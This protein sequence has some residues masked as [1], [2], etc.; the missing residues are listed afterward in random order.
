M[1]SDKPR[2]F[3]VQA[4][5]DPVIERLCEVADV[6]V[7]PRLDRQISL[8]ETVDG[9][10]RA[11]YLLALHGNYVPA[12]VMHA[13]PRL[14][15]LAVLGD[16]TVKVDFD[17]ARQYR[18]PVVTSR[19]DDLKNLPGGGY[20]QATAD[21][22]VAML[23]SLAYRLFDADRYTRKSATF[24]EQTMALMGIGAPGNTVGL[25]GLGK[26]A[27]HMVPRLRPFEMRILYCKRTRLDPAE[28]QQLGIEWV[29]MDE[30]LRQSD[31]V[32]VEVDYNETTHELLGEREFLLMKP[33][34]YLLNTAR[35]R[36][37]DE[38][39]L[40]RALQN[41]T[42]AGAG[43]DVFYHEPPLMWDPMVP[44]ELRK[45][46]NVI[47]APH[48]GGATYGSRTAQIMP[49]AEGIVS[50]IRGER[51]KGLLNPEVYGE[52]VLYP[53]FYGRGPIVPVV[54]G[55]PA[56]FPVI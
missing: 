14:K 42:I 45:M 12:E 40:I 2:V 27:R 22:T 4:I 18:I 28:E 17:T 38:K 8:Q 44:E 20:N 15:G 1:P 50:L 29:E 21:L 34:A 55:G 52:P 33:T 5:P 31:F 10:K 49:L 16:T 39:A 36:I 11:D 30:L 53:Q 7:F 46:E 41:G 47:L 26:V 37:L 25:I 35:G 54:D 3:V 6:E 43:L 9:A 56:N 24:Q 32:C 48:N 51:P 23:L 19:W 13:N